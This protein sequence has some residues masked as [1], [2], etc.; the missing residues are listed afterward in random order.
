MK[1]RIFTVDKIRSNTNI[2]S[3]MLSISSTLNTPLSRYL[4]T[5]YNVISNKNLN[6]QSFFWLVGYQLT[7]LLLHPV[8]TRPIPSRFNPIQPYFQPAKPY[9]PL[10]LTCFRNAMD[11]KLLTNAVDWLFFT[12]SVWGFMFDIEA[13]NLHFT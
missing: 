11:R 6:Y 12:L 2:L 3:K 10:K 8:P 9:F 4:S 1:I 13:E 5:I 7:L